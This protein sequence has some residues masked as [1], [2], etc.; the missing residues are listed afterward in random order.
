VWFG[1]S[2][3]AVAIGATVAF[4]E[5]FTEVFAVLFA[6][7][8]TEAFAGAFASMAPPEVRGAHSTGR[9]AREATLPHAGAPDGISRGRAV[10]SA[11][12][13][14]SSASAVRVRS[15]SIARGVFHGS[16]AGFHG[17]LDALGGLALDVG[18]FDAPAAAALDTPLATL[19]RDTRAFAVEPSP[20]ARSAVTM[21]GLA[22]I[23][24][25]ANNFVAFFFI[26]LAPSLTKTT[27]SP[28]C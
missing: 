15:V 11:I 24:T 1:A 20:E 3:I 27:E 16:R 10:T 23:T 9:G 6:G 22:A 7:L 28:E 18:A 12:L 4:A 19:S 5:L 8:S 26:R 13:P 14:S 21:P 2:W 25:T 17:S